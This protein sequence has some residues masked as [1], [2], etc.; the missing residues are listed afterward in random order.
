MALAVTLS[1][2]A[3]MRFDHAARSPIF[4]APP[5]PVRWQL[6]Q[7]AC[8]ICSPVRPAD[9]AGCATAAAGSFQFAPAWFARYAT[10]RAISMSLRSGFPP[11]GG[12]ARIPFMESLTST[13]M[14]SL[15]SGAQAALSPVFGAPA[16]PVPWHA[17]QTAL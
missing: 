15:I 8:T 1:I 11:R 16:A 4:G 7:P 10:A 6:L 5:S 9:A 2:P 14:P 13:S 12:M 17:V 3:E